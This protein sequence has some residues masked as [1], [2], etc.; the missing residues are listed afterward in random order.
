MFP[1]VSQGA[2]AE[3]GFVEKPLKPEKTL[4]RAAASYCSG[5]ESTVRQPTKENYEH[6]EIEQGPHRDYFNAVGSLLYGSHL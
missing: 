3:E 4:P 5:N 6:D 1:Q 2:L